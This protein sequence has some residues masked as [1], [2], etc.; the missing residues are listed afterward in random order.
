MSQLKK[1]VSHFSP[2]LVTYGVR[3]IRVHSKF[4]R[5][6][7]SH[8]AEED[9]SSA[10]GGHFSKLEDNWRTHKK[11]L[12]LGGQAQIFFKIRGQ[13]EVRLEDKIPDWRTSSSLDEL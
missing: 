4:H 10:G 2:L 6:Q 3:Y 7:F 9:L 13:F 12:Q 5:S 8:F 1:A 11:V